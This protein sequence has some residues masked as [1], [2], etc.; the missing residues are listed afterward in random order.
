MRSYQELPTG[1]MLVKFVGRVTCQVVDVAG[2]QALVGLETLQEYE[3][4]I[5]KCKE[6]GYDETML[7]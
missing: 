7:G 6:F 2:N 5:D 1:S 3:K 4:L